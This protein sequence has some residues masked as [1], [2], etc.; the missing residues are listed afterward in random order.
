MHVW[1]YLAEAKIY[2]PYEKK[3]DFKII[4]GYFI[5]YLENPE[6]IGFTILH[7]V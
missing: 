6:S 5:G 7:I 3:L 4:S 1:G 2:N